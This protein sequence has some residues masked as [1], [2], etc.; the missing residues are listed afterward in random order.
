MMICWRVR[1]VPLVAGA[2]SLGARRSLNASTAILGGIL[3]ATMQVRRPAHCASNAQRAGLRL[4]L[5][6]QETRIQ[7]V[8]AAQEV[9]S[10]Q[11]KAKL[12]ACLAFQ[13]STTVISE[14]ASAMIVTPACSQNMPSKRTVNHVLVGSPKSTQVNHFA[15]SV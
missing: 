3:Q 7:H 5:D 10:S 8:R 12:F 11:T 4:V 2:Q 14:Q 9:S 1:V 6:C 15:M 13:E